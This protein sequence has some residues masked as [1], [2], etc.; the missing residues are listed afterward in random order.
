MTRTCA[1]PGCGRQTP[2]ETHRYCNDC[3]GTV[4]RTGRPPVIERAGPFT[5]EWRKRAQAKDLTGA[6][7]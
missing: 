6:A 5:P 1:T 2:H 3:I 4:L 7:A